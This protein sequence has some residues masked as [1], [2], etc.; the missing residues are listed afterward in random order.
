[1]TWSNTNICPSAKGDGRCHRFLPAT[2]IFCGE[3]TMRNLY[4]IFV[5]VTGLLP[6]VTTQA[7]PADL[8]QT[9]QTICYDATGAVV[10]CAGTGQDGELMT[11]AAWPSPRFVVG[12]TTDRTTH[13]LTGPLWARAP[14][15]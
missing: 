11:G 6:F 4:L 1:M 7:A 13:T 8:P 14:G 12:P 9:G 2:R 3:P 10:T 5:L 15:F